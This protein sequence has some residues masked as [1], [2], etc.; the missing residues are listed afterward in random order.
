MHMHMHIHTHT[1]AHT[2]TYIHTHI[3]THTRLQPL[4]PHQVELFRRPSEARRVPS[5]WKEATLSE[6]TQ[7][8]LQHCCDLHAAVRHEAM[9]LFL[10][11]APL[12]TNPDTGRPYASARAWLG[13]FGAPALV[14]LVETQGS[15]KPILKVNV[16]PQTHSRGSIYEW[17][18][19]LQATLEAFKLVVGH[20][21]LPPA[22]IFKDCSDSVHTWEA[23]AHFFKTFPQ[24]SKLH[25]DDLQSEKAS[26][27]YLKC[28]VMVRILDFLRT[29][30]RIDATCVPSELWRSK[31]A[32]DFLCNA[33]LTP[34]FVDFDPNDPEIEEKLP[35]KTGLSLFM[36]ACISTRKRE[37]ASHRDTHRHMHRQTDRHTHTQAHTDTH[38]QAHTARP[39][40]LL[41]TRPRMSRSAVATIPP[42]TSAMR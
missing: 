11:L 4:L 20:R 42:G 39:Y 36:L 9:E 26:Y 3:H 40:L 13:S 19:R 31:G 1:H 15:A 10:H 12:D 8:A 27:D 41:R 6:L 28:T 14:S 37:S 7:W 29:L 18:E 34:V 25:R 30:L 5:E 17:L 23:L 2:H 33:V 24:L 22:A 38:T 16:H 35:Q 32:L 21:L